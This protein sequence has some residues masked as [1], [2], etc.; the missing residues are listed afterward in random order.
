[1][2]KFT[3][4]TT[5][6]MMSIVMIAM[7][8]MLAACSSNRPKESTSNDKIRIVTTI[9]Q[10]A[11]P[12]SVIGAEHVEVL[13]LMGPG[14]DPH[15]YNAT[16]GDIQKLQSGD[17]VLYSGLHLE[18]K[19]GEVFEQ[20]GK[21]KPVLGIAESI[22]EDRLLHNKGGAIDPHVWFDI[23]LW[24]HAL[25][26]AVEEMKQFAPDYADY[27]ETNKQAYFEQLDT[28]QAE[29]KQKLSEIEK[30]KR[31]IVTAH[32]A[33]GYFGRSNEMQVVGLQ[34]ISTA[35]EIGISNIN[36][37]IGQL[38][39]YNIPAVF[40]ESSINPAS[41]NAVIEGAGSK[42]LKVKL[43]GELFSDAMGKEGTEEG[44]Y[45]GMYKHNVDTIYKALTG[46]GE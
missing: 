33:F 4:N 24:K 38:L 45:L 9:G 7:S 2:R 28:L 10:I 16:Q 17:I 37:T 31:V 36:D 41:I 30:D 22:P 8:L 46:K 20:I 1:M 40:I 15:L 11:E 25:N 44:T 29:S 5:L 27:F 18:G 13:S 32:D 12:I 6:R 42:G 35:A 21:S 39:E 26:A 3:I 14:V 43:G 19:M 23:V 34:G